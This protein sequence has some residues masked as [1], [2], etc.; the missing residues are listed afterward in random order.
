MWKHLVIPSFVYLVST[1]LASTGLAADKPKTQTTSTTVHETA[2]V[3]L[4][5]IP[6]NVIGRDGKPVSGLEAADFQIEDDGDRQTVL[7]LD[8]IDLNKKEETNGVGEPIPP[9]GRRHFLLLFDLSFSKPNQIVRAREAAAHF[10]ETA[11]DPDDL[12]AVAVSSVDLGA[13]LLVT[14]T[15]DRRQ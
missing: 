6:V 9:A 5:E 4:V 13:R 14:F 7:S 12:A 11:V 3:S 1:G 10:L 2:E 15:S 8:V